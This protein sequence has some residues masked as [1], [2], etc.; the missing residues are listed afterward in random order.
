VLALSFPDVETY[1]RVVML[2]PDMG[3]PDQQIKRKATLDY[4]A[5]DESIPY[6]VREKGAK[7]SAAT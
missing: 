6:R 2:H 5:S 1:Q 3:S 7:M 4:L